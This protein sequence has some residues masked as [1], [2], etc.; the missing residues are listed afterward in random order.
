MKSSVDDPTGQVLEQAQKLGITVGI[1]A[2]LTKCAIV[3]GG[4][5]EMAVI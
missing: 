4:R 3:F 1:F 2:L 5:F